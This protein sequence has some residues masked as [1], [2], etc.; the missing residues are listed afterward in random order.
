MQGRVQ[1]SFFHGEQPLGGFLDVQHDAKSVVRAA[2]EG[3]EDQQ[4]QRA[5]EIVGWLAGRRSLPL[6]A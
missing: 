5:L 1:G 2:G 3:F 6:G 4:S